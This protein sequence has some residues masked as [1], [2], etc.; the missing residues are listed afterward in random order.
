MKGNIMTEQTVPQEAPETIVIV[1]AP[2]RRFTVTR[3]KIA[4]AGAAT[5]A[6]AGLIYL[7][8][9]NN[10]SEPLFTDESQDS[11]NAASSD[12]PVSE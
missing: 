10:E 8:V 5:A 7:K 1:E 3:K 11:S 9:R 4:Y 12:T 6:L 2:A